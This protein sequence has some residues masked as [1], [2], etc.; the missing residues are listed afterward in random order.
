[1]GMAIQARRLENGRLL[2]PVT[3]R[4]PNGEIGCGMNEIGPGDP[5]YDEWLAWFDQQDRD[6]R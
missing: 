5:L 2:V 4:G 6:G 1:M 3:G